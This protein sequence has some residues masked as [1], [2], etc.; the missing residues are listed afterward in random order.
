MPCMRRL[1]VLASL[2]GMV[3]RRTRHSENDIMPERCERAKHTNG[4]QEQSD[5]EVLRNLGA[6]GVCSAGQSLE[7]PKLAR[8]QAQP[9][10]PSGLITR[11]LSGDSSQSRLDSTGSGGARTHGCANIIASN[12]DL[13]R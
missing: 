6:I 12:W 2:W 5:K 7:L 3:Q 1:I 9:Y 13:L 8:R 4:K 11:R 10:E